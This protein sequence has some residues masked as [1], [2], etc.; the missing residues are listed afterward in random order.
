M[1]DIWSK[2][3]SEVKSQA[4]MNWRYDLSIVERWAYIITIAKIE[5]NW[6]DMLHFLV[7]TY[8]IKEWVKVFHNNMLPSILFWVPY[9]LRWCVA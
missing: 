7:N 9:L 3:E 8:L 1:V 5:T 6:G 4:K 2:V